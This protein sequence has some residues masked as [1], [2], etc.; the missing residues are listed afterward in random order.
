MLGY[1]TEYVQN[2]DNNGKKK[3]YL[4]QI[5]LHIFIESSLFQLFPVL[6]TP[7]GKN[8]GHSRA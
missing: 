3:L 2:N 6:P 8:L 7:V 1:T 4:L 5:F